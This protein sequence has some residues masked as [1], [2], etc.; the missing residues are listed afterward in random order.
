MHLTYDGPCVW[1]CNND[2]LYVVAL[3]CVPVPLLVCVCVCVCVCVSVSVSVCLCLCLCQD[4]SQAIFAEV[5]KA[6]GV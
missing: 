3:I 5:V 2:L 1:P 6:T 4:G